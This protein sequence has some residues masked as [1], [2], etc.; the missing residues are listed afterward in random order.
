MISHQIGCN[1]FH[2]GYPFDSAEKGVAIYSNFFKNE[3]I[4]EITSVD[5]VNIIDL[6]NKKEIK[7]IDLNNKSFEVDSEVLKPGCECFTC[8]NNYTKAYI[9]HL[10]KCKEL[11]ASILIAM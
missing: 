7:L 5:E 3:E 6:A 2:V 11:N 9:H 8:K 4:S 1:Y 10:L